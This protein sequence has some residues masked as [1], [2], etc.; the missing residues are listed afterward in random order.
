MKLK[1]YVML[2]MFFLNCFSSNP[3]HHSSFPYISGDTFRS[4]SYHILDNTQTFEPKH[5]KVGDVIFVECVYLNH[6][7]AVLHPR[8]TVPYIL[9]THNGDTHVPGYYASY[10][11]DPKLVAW[12]GQNIDMIHP[13]LHALPIGLANS[14]YQHG[15]TA[16]YEK[17]RV[18]CKDRNRTK[19]LYM[20][21]NTST[22]PSER[23]EVYAMFKNKPFCTVRTN[24]QLGRYLEDITQHK[25]VL[26][27]R[28][29]GLDCHRT[30][31]ALL[32]G[33]YPIVKTSILDVL[34]QDLPVVIVDDWS[35]VTE[36]FLNQKYEEMRSKK[37]TI[38][39]LFAAY[40]LN[41]IRSVQSAMWADNLLIRK[42]IICE[43]HPV[44]FDDKSVQL[45]ELV[46]K[47]INNAE[48]GNSK[49]NDTMLQLEGLSSAKVRHL[50]N[51][52]CA[53]QGTRYLE[54]GVWKGANFISALYG[55]E[56]ETIEA[57]AVDKWS[58]P[59]WTVKNEFEALAR[60]HLKNNYFRLY[61]GDYLNIAPVSA[62][63]KLI[64]LCFFDGDHN[65]E[66]QCKA[67]KHFNII[68]DNVFVAVVDDW[69]YEDVQIATKQ[70]FRELGYHVL[71]ERILNSERQNDIDGWWN[72]LYVA[73]V[74]KG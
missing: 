50:L 37:F 26:S 66:S 58:A 21:F 30:W 32:M 5:V 19:L 51:N 61:D 35:E 14:Y 17:Y 4:F 56:Q 10:L 22:Y 16:F 3:E 60:Q 8:I 23:N 65:I 31:E 69:N 64:N 70:A 1:F 49:L 43:P 44:I 45:I 25:F 68:M 46:K 55:N 20:N 28:G 59:K 27:P 7:F 67:F 13:K 15:N 54:I 71:Y 39:R 6:F 24:L 73:V 47:S 2:L 9:L 41:Q 33:S 63:K 18:C 34:Y 62:F 42:E 40:W 72:G 12:F 36:D 11:D 52:L 48:Q 38:N 53:R 57:I 29:N 74:H